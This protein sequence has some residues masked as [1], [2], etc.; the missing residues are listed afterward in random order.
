MRPALAL[1]VAA[2]WLAASG[3]GWSA[4]SVAG[5]FTYRVPIET[6]PAP[7]GLE[8]E[9]ALTYSSARV[10][11]LTSS[12]NTQASWAGEGWDYHPGYVERAYRLCRNDGV[13]YTGGDLCWVAVSPLTLTLNGKTT[14]IVAADT[15]WKAEDDSEGWKVERLTGVDNGVLS[16]ESFKVTT[17]DGT[18]YFFGSRRAGGP[19]NGGDPSGS[20]G[21]PLVVQVYGNNAGEPCYNSSGFATSSCQMPY[22][23]NLDKVVDVHDNV[24][25]YEWY[26]DRASYGGNNAASVYQ[27][28][29]GS[30]LNAVVYGKNV[31]AG[32]V[33]TGRVQ[34]I[35]QNRCLG[36]DTV[37]NPATPAN[38]VNWPDTPW[39]QFCAATATACG[40]VTPVFFS[41][42]RL[43]AIE[44]QLWQPG[45]SS[46]GLVNRWDFG[47]T[48]PTHSDGTTPSLWLDS[49]T[50][51]GF[52][53]PMYTSG[54]DLTN[55]VD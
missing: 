52:L 15:G 5:D 45:S 11:G 34:F 21:G 46:W 42:Y 27:Y 6:P 49:I 25:E 48:F 38:W 28:D 24:I 7:G 44:T 26:R 32:S 51:P 16:G 39:D 31:T 22:R 10:D 33:H 4:G 54:V 29:H 40:Q 50:R 19:L 35:A 2:L 18:Q 1:A 8:P 12:K 17:R 9:V 47:Y 14:R 20:Y 53:N 55:R 3:T 36:T 37:C 23:W 13:A 43:G 41:L 30:R